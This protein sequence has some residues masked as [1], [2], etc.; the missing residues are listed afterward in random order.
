MCRATNE[1][2]R[3]KI[4]RASNDPSLDPAQNPQEA[5]LAV[6]QAQP[7]PHNGGRDMMEKFSCLH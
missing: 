1:H 6:R 5:S 2:L 7:L 3:Q 4:H